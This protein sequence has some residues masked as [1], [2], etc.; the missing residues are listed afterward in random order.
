METV[1]GKDNQ[2]TIP[3]LG[4]AVTRRQAIKAG[5]I[6]VVGLAFSK[7]L[8][9]TLM[10]KPAFA[11]YVTNGNGAGACTPGYWK[12]PHHFDDW[13]IPTGTT[14]GSVFNFGAA[15]VPSSI[16]A[17]AGDSFL[18]A[19]AYPGGSSLAAKAQIMLRAA[20]A[21]YLNAGAFS[22]YP[23]SSGAIVNM[24]NDALLEQPD[25]KDVLINLGTLFDDT[26]NSDDLECRFMVHGPEA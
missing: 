9:E 3:F 24:V 20:A 21:A 26:N 4:R 6:A 19:L 17:L 16:A 23:F 25:H 10:P 12:Q 15:G 1:K 5:G 8:I 2:E 14:L 18:T 13:P 11:N 7:P 22:G